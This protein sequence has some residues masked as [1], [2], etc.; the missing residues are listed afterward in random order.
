M[1]KIFLTTMLI[2]LSSVL[3]GCH[4]ID[5]GSAQLI[6]GSGAAVEGSS[7]PVLAITAAELDIVEKMTVHRRAYRETLVSQ[8]D[9]YTRTGNNLKLQWA[10]KELKALD[11]IPRYNYIIEAN[12]AGSGL[13]ATTSIYE[14][15][16][17]YQ[18]AVLLEKQA[19]VLLIFK[20]EVLLRSIRDKYNEVIRKYPTSDK[21]D[22]AAFRAGK[23]FEHFKDYSIAVL[24]YQ[25]TYQWDAETPYSA[26]YR[27]AYLLDKKLNRKPEALELYKQ[28]LEQ[29]QLSPESEESI[30][31]RVR[32]L[33]KSDKVVD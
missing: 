27:A 22:D 25:R 7:F 9:Y 29:G 28:L 6:T 18:N 14:A 33:T 20:D 23:I 15:D 2:V 8:I 16:N 32:E 13:R 4:D 17:L 30:E 3:I 5:G 24:Y 19:N 12:L 1:A 31:W 11:S 21:I 10:R 26:K